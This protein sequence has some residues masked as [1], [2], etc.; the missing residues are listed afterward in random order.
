M[1]FATNAGRALASL[2]LSGNRLGEKVVR[3]VDALSGV[4]VKRSSDVKDEIVL[5]G[6]AESSCGPFSMANMVGVVGGAMDGCDELIELTST[7]DPSC[8]VQCEAGYGTATAV[9]TWSRARRLRFLTYVENTC[10]PYNFGTGVVAG[11]IAEA[12]AIVGRVEEARHEPRHVA[13]IRQ[14]IRGG[15]PA[16][17]RPIQPG[18]VAR[19][20]RESVDRKSVV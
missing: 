15:R 8:T 16:H 5:D 10:A 9:I 17:H 19:L 14:P 13:L 3:V 2:T 12:V 4:T 6:C 7:S 1:R 18:P 20:L 11:G